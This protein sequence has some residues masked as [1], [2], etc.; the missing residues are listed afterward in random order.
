MQCDKV[1]FLKK[2]CPVFQSTM[3]ELHHSFAIV[4]TEAPTRVGRMT[5]PAEAANGEALEDLDRGLGWMIPM[6]M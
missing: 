4:K 2:L 1:R 6:G 5:G 3:T